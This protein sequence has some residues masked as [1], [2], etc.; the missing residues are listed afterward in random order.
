MKSAY[1]QYLGTQAIKLSSNKIAVTE[2]ISQN[3]DFNKI[4]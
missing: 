4:Y 1:T 2:T 3:P